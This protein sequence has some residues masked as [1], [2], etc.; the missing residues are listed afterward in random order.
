MKIIDQGL[1]RY[2][3]QQ[4]LEGQLSNLAVRH[5]MKCKQELLHRVTHGEFQGTNLE[6]RVRGILF[7][8][9]A[10]DKYTFTYDPEN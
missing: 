8:L 7:L 6:T 10:D 3:E 1:A 4:C 2:L 9:G 5:G